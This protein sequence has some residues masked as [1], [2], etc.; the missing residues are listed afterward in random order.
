MKRFLSCVVILCFIS[1]NSESTDFELCGGGLY[2]YYHPDLN[3]EG[4]FYAIKEHF[5][6]NYRAV[7]IGNNSGI[8][9]VRFHVNCKGETGNYKVET[10]SFDYE[11]IEMNNQITDQLLGLTKNL[12]KWIPG[13]DEEGELINSH[14]FFAF[15]IVKGQLTEILPK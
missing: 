8:V 13:K 6:T 11:L 5:K 15:K 10:Y 12:K 1:C 7:S 2:P 14:K 4:S 3:Y 9:K